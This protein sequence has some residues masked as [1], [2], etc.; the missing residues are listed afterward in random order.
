MRKTRLGREIKQIVL[1]DYS[2]TTSPSDKEAVKP[3]RLNSYKLILNVCDNPSVS[4]ILTHF[5]INS[6]TYIAVESRRKDSVELDTTI[7]K[8]IC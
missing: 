5:Q 2:E 6:A 8:F 7:G 1:N 3:K 4:W